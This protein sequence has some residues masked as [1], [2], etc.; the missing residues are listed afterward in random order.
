MGQPCSRRQRAERIHTWGA[1]VRGTYG[2]PEAGTRA[3]YVQYARPWGQA[4]LRLWYVHYA[5]GWYVPNGGPAAYASAQIH[6][7]RL[8]R[9]PSLMGRAECT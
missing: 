5:G 1:T 7:T 4:A 2:T 3:P 8:S 9:S 6:T